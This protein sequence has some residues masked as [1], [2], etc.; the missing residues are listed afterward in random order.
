MLNADAGGIDVSRCEDVGL[1]AL[2]GAGLEGLRSAET[3]VI[4]V[5]I[6]AVDAT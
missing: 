6:S 5:A 1:D 4:G 2:V 3:V